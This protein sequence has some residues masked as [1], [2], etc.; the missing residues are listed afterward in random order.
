MFIS[1]LYDAC[2]LNENSETH[3]VHAFDTKNVY[4]AQ[5]FAEADVTQCSYSE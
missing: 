5:K 2:A 4:L 1:S 3:G